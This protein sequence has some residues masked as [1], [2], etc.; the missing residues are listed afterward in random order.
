MV[1]MVV[2][3]VG[4]LIL[5]ERGR[6]IDGVVVNEGGGGRWRANVDTPCRFANVVGVGVG[7]AA[8]NIGS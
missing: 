5:L 6:R 3:V 2:V 4:S 8:A 1:M 7:S